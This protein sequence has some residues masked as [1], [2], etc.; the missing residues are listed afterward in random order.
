MSKP[1]KYLGVDYGAK[2]VGVAVG[3]LES[4]ITEALVTLA[5]S[6]SLIQELLKLRDEH[7][8]DSIILG[9]PRNL[10]G[11]DTQ[12]TVSV[13]RFALELEKNGVAVILQ[14]EALTSEQAAAN[15]GSKKVFQDK[16]QVD[17]EA[18]RIIV[19]DYLRECRKT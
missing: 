18:A 5:N 15:I 17:R 8:A 12:Q 19:E 14:D 13:R 6:P 9:L 16:G 7:D 2:R 4:G 11:E 10:E 3:N 1:K